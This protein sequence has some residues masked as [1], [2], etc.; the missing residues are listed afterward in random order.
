MKNGC[1]EAY[2]ADIFDKL[3]AVAQHTELG[4]SGNGTNTKAFTASDKIN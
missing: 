4:T 3:E 1:Q 2:L